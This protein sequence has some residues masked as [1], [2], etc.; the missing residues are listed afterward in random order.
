[1]STQSQVFA[2]DL[3]TYI[4][5]QEKTPLYGKSFW[6]NRDSRE[7]EGSRAEEI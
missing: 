2:E 5:G 3:R 1:M 6:L 7:V 4:R